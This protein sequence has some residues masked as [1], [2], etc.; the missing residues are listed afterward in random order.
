MLN[1]LTVNEAQSAAITHGDGPM[2]VLAGPGSGKTFVI[3]QRIK[4]LIEELHV[5]IVHPNNEALFYSRDLVFESHEL[6]PASLAY[7]PA[8][9]K[10]ESGDCSFLFL[11]G[12]C[13]TLISLYAEP[14]LL[15]GIN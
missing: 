6:M 15:D 3:T 13:G 11:T 9:I 14:W 2:L 4:Y 7:F 1:H 8:P 10:R 5:D 12:C